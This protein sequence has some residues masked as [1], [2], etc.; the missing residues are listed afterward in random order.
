MMRGIITCRTIAATA[1]PQ[2]RKDQG[3]MV[4]LLQRTVEDC[5]S[6]VPCKDAAAGGGGLREVT[7]RPRHV[8]ARDQR[9]IET[10][11]L[12]LTEAH[13][14]IAGDGAVRLR[15]HQEVPTPRSLPPASRCTGCARA[16][17][18]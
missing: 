11:S 13:R 12:S 6:N 5:Q 4:A 2:R 14:G 18:L 3:G 10:R 8:K 16:P 9:R 15:A 7:R 1:T 17:A